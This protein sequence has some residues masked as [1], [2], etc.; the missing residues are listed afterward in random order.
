MALG[1][2]SLFFLV[3]LLI[4]LHGCMAPPAGVDVLD[5]WELPQDAGVYLE[6]EEADRPLWADQGALAADYRR[7]FFSPW[8]A[9]FPVRPRSEAFWMIP[10]LKG[11]TIYGENRRPVPPE[12]VEAVV[13]AAGAASFPSLD[14]PAITVRPSDLRSL[15]SRRPFFLDPAK[16]GEGF[17]FD[18]LQNSGIAAN[19]PVRIRHRTPDGAWVYVDG[20]ALYGWLPAPDVAVVDEEFMRSFRTSALAVLVRDGVPVVD[21]GGVFRFTGRIGTF[22]PL[23]SSDASGRIVGLV[24]AADADGRAVLRQTPLPA[25][26]AALFPL[27]ATPRRLAAVAN[28]MMGEPYGWGDLYGDRDCSSTLR[29]LYAPFG[30]WLPRNSA[31]QAEAGRILSLEKL[32]P[33]ERERALLETGVPWRTLLWMK[34]HVM[35]YL[36]EYRGRATVFHALWG[37]RTRDGEGEEGRRVVGRTVVTTLQPGRELPDLA[38]EGDLR[39]RLRGI[40]LLGA[41]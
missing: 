18:Y 30:F 32:S 28:R 21:G 40:T 11:K 29:D 26:G 17:P 12:K 39:E 3:S 2:R 22:F 25:D 9:P 33:E 35:L 24:A 36:G 5:L 6:P 8:E 19:T 23:V 34:G 14:L 1:G 20:T 7:R 38:P 37:V 10:W 13:A 16:P 4:L 15:P 31:A 41:P 27:P